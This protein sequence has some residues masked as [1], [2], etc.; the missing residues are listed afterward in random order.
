M[1]DLERPRPDLLSVRM[2]HLRRA[3]IRAHVRAY[4]RAYVRAV[5]RAVGGSDAGQLDAGT[6]A[7]VADPRRR[8]GASRPGQACG[9]VQA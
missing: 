4:A 3:D 2:W 6:D 7:T 8:R 9:S 1:C 5:G